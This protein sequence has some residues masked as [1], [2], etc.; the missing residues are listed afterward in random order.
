VI[1]HPLLQ[2]GER[3]AIAELGLQLRAELRLSAR[4]LEEEHELSGDQPGHLGPAI[5]LDQ[6]EG[7]VHARGH[8]GGR[9]EV[10]LPH[11]DGIGVHGDARIPLGES[12]AAAPVRGGPLAVEE[13][14]RPLRLGLT[15]VCLPD[16]TRCM[17]S[18]SLPATA[19]LAPAVRHL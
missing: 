18:P 5:L 15:K 16:G 11:E 8:A 14:G 9:E 10:P 2:L 19:S 1:G 7:Q 3:L 4:T 13:T 6:S 17:C 12:R